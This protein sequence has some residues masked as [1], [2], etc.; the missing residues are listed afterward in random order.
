MILDAVFTEEEEMKTDFGV[1]K[2][3][4]NGNGEI[5][6]PEEVISKVLEEYLKEHPI[7]GGG[8]ENGYTYI[9]EV[10][11]TKADKISIRFHAMKDGVEDKDKTF[12]E[13]I[14]L[15]KGADG[16]SGVYIGTE[17]PT[18]ESVNV[19]I[20]PEG[21]VDNPEGGNATMHP[22]TFTG[23][24]KAT[25]DGSKAVS[26]EIPIGGGFEFEEVFVFRNEEEVNVLNVRI[27]PEISI[28][29][30]N[31]PF[32]I[33][34]FYARRV[35]SAEVIGGSPTGTFQVLVLNNLGNAIVTRTWLDKKPFLPTSFIEN[36][37]DA[38]TLV[39]VL[40]QIGINVID[41]EYGLTNRGKSRAFNQTV[42]N[43][44]GS[45]ENGL[46]LKITATDTAIGA[47]SVLRVRVVK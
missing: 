6:I 37:A 4:N 7:E 40:K 2:I 27:P 33:V 17:E 14:T 19:W 39:I 29:M 30:K 22:L 41:F 46:C 13:T 16:K 36:Q 32:V 31:S 3:I 25:Y 44:Y 26:V 47:G 28:K 1:V 21:I 38:G 9:P 23:A 11:Q 24:V 42:D 12:T 43:V 10:I 45:V 5:D 20:D 8:G 18:D 15:P 34:D 35:S